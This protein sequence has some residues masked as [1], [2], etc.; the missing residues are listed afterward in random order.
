[1]SGEHGW[2][3]RDR[4]A[5]LVETAMVVTLLVAVAAGIAELSNAWQARA[6]VERA[7]HTMVRALGA[8][9]PSASTDASALAIAAAFGDVAGIEV[10]RVVVFRSQGASGVVPAVCRRLWPTTVSPSGVDGVCNV[11]GPAHLARVARGVVWAGCGSSSPQQFWCPATR[12][13]VRP[14]P[15]R[16]GVH[17]D[18]WVDAPRLSW[19]SGQRRSVATTAVVELDPEVS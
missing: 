10:R 5:V 11:Y 16:L 8:A 7:S 17:L 2:V 1:M 14:D 9:T 3:G 18:L 19:R 13:R 6:G 4:G 15:D 12:S